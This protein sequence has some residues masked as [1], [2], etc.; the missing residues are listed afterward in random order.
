[1]LLNPQSERPARTRTAH[2]Y[3]LKT[4]RE[5]ILDGRLAGGTHLVQSDLATELGVSVTPVR[6]ALRDLAAEGLV[7]VDPHRGALVRTLDL[8]EVQELYEL[9]M[10]LEPLMVRRSMA[11]ISAE[12]IERAGSLHRKMQLTENIGEWVELNRQF[13]ETFAETKE[14]RLSNI[15]AGLRASASSYV[16][17]S[18]AASPS[19]IS[20]SN[21]EHAELIGLYKAGDVER[22][23]QLTVQ[24]LQTTLATIEEAHQQGII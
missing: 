2:A 19:R 14:S 4:L 8:A 22:I 9:R 16:G 11:S 20:Q 7:E 13:H 15:L 23:I 21:E 24:H 12:Q 10:T 5:A 1:M 18:L 6:E 17:L 3:V